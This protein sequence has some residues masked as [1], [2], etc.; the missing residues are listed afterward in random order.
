MC[1]IGNKLILHP[2]CTCLE[3]FFHNEWVKGDMMMVKMRKEWNMSFEE[4]KNNNQKFEKEGRHDDGWYYIICYWVERKKK[5][6]GKEVKRI[7]GYI[8]MMIII[9]KKVKINE[10][11]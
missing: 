11:H 10:R 1:H 9:R 7:D 8:C 2:K 4:K 6:Y 3:L 5:D